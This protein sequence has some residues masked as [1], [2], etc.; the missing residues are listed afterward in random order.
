MRAMKRVGRPPAEDPTVAVT[1]RLPHSAVE[2]L[3]AVLRER[4]AGRPGTTRQDL[5]REAVGRYLAA[6]R[7]KAKKQSA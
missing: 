4:R 1:A 7:R 5:L 3:D 2:A 6:E